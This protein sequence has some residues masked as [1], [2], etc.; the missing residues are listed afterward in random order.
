MSAF[1]S[2]SRYLRIDSWG[3]LPWLSSGEDS[4]FSVQE[5]WVQS[6]VGE[7]RSHVLRRTAKKKDSWI[8]SSF[9][10]SLH[11]S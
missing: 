3:T 2:S 4:E 8:E 7:L 1:G 6:L 9:P 11:K 10:T 5:V